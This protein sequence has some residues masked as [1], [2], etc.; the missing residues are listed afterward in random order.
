MQSKGG[1]VARL[2][3]AG[4]GAKAMHVIHCIRLDTALAECKLPSFEGDFKTGNRKG[5]IR[6]YLKMI[7]NNRPQLRLLIT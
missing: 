2:E 7:M 6:V 4:A 3:Y 5:D 1:I